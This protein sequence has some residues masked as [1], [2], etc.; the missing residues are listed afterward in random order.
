MDTDTQETHDRLYSFTFGDQ[1]RGYIMGIDTTT[2]E[3]REAF[4][5]EHARFHEMAPEM[6]PKEIAFPH[7]RKPHLLKEAHTM[8]M[9]QFYRD[10][11]IR[12]EMKNAVDA[13]RLS[14]GDHDAAVKFLGG[15]RHID[16]GLYCLYKGGY[17]KGAD[18]G[19]DAADKALSAIGYKFEVN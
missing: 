7:E 9:Y 19:F 5:K 4:R 13:G 17:A 2:E 11:T 18:A 12:N 14:Q 16:V 1:K 3:G 15:K 8:R 6:V 10:Q